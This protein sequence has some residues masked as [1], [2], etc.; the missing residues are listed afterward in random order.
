MLDDEIIAVAP[1]DDHSERA[2]I[3]NGIVIGTR[4]DG[5]IVSVIGD[6]IGARAAF[7]GYGTAEV[8]V[9]NEV[10]AVAAVEQR[11]FAA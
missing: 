5:D 1:V 3:L 4:V 8:I 6:D 11:A 9:L 2:V 7:D 10:R